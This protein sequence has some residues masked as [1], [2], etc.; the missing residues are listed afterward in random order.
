MAFSIVALPD[1]KVPSERAEGQGAAD[2][3]GAARAGRGIRQRVAQEN[4]RQDLLRRAPGRDPRHRGRRGQRPE[5]AGRHALRLP[6]AERGQRHG[7]GGEHPRPAAAEAAQ[8][9][10]LARAGGPDALRHRRLRLD[11]GK[12]HLRPLGGKTAEPRASL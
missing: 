1:V 12:P 7:A 8:Q 9:G 6:D 11:R 3:R 4:A 5:G 2:G 10:H